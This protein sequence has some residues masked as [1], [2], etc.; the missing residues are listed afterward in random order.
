MVKFKICVRKKRRDGLWPV[1]IRLTQDTQVKYIRTDK[2]V[3][4]DGLKGNEVTDP[5]VTK[6][7]MDRIVEYVEKLN[8]KNTAGWS[9]NDILDYLLRE[10]EE[11]CFSDY[12]RGFIDDM[13]NRN[14]DRNARNYQLALQHME[15]FF[16]TN[17][18][19]FA[20][21]TSYAVA[22]WIRSLSTT[23]RA[24]EMYPV[25]MRQ[26]FKSAC[27]EMN[28]Y[29][30]GIIRIKTNPWVKVDIPTAD[31][32]EHLAITPQD[33]RAFFAAAIPESRLKEPL[34]EI[35][36][37]IAKLVLC[38]AGINVVDL[39]NMQKR[40][41][42]DGI[43]HYKRAKTRKARADEAY[44]EMRVPAI[45]LPLFDK[46][47]AAPEDPY[48]F[49]FHRRFS[50]SDSMG[51]N[52]NRGIKQI[53]AS[54]GIPKEDWYCIYTFRHTWG[55]IAQ[56]DCDASLDDVAFAMNHANGHK[57]TRG[58]LK[59]DFT[60]AWELND[61]VIEFVFFTDKESRRTQHHEQEESFEKFSA[62]HLMRG[63]IYFQGRTL[64]S[65][66]D[67]GFHNVEEII[68]AL[69]RYIPD[70][71]PVRS[72]LQFKIENLDKKQQAIYER[73]RGKTV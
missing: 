46:Y 2:L 31:K 62:K 52:A 13:I 57:V 70:D 14:Q 25:C 60:P 11:I 17:K 3:C 32:A 38:L 24:K 30:R 4:D 47:M 61:K 56:N 49:M 65:V 33:C 6:Y 72:M 27:R 10:D 45:L 59:I 67:I 12:A 21:L 53:C 69:T 39:Y 55:T 36:R 50:S 44:I 68:Q 63:T 26:V 9:L 34:A 1:Y 5:F 64:G 48:L 66:E 37:D 54:M 71:V 16:G 28:D 29:D 42:Y 20:M 7:G 15:R 35:G 51:A 23:R 43:I 8:R 73:M 58:Y 41:Y 19:M 18:I 40:D 22:K